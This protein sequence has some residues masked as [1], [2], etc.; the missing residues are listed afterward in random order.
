V[1]GETCFYTGISLKIVT[2]RLLLVK[3]INKVKR[4][5]FDFRMPFAVFFQ[6]T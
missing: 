3:F 2:V 5:H 4:V 6:T 1:V